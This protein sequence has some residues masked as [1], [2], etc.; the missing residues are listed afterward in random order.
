MGASLRPSTSANHMR[1][2]IIAH[3]GDSAHR[4]E[5]TRAAFVRAVEVG[6]D[7][8]ELDVQLTREGHVVVFHDEAVDRTTDGEGISNS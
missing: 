2:L 6:A 5:N 7:M 4:P 3:R 1:P 8:V